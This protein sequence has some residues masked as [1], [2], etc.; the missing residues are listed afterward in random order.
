MSALKPIFTSK[1]AERIKIRLFRAAIDSILCYG[2]ET[3]P[4]MPTLSRS[5]DSRYRR[6]LRSALGIFYPDRI[7]NDELFAKTQL[8]LLSTTLRRRRL[9]LVGHILR[10]QTRSKSPLGELLLN[11][12]SGHLRPSSQNL[13]SDRAVS[14]AGRSL[15]YTLLAG[16]LL[17]ADVTMAM[18][19]SLWNNVGGNTVTSS[20]ATSNTSRVVGQCV[21]ECHQMESC[22][23]VAFDPESDICYLQPTY[24]P[25]R[26]GDDGPLDVYTREK[27]APDVTNAHVTK[28]RVTPSSLDGDVSC[29]ADY[30]LSAEERPQVRCWL[31]SGAWTTLMN[32]TCK[33]FAWRNYTVHPVV[34]S[35]PR[36]STLGLCVRVK[37]TPTPTP[38]N[39]TRV[40]VNLGASGN[41]IVLHVSI[42]WNTGGYEKATILNYKRGTDWNMSKHVE[43]KDPSPPFLF[44]AGVP[45]VM[46]ITAVSLYTFTV[47]VNGAYYGNFTGVLPVTD[48]IN[49]YAENDVSIEYLIIGC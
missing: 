8:P 3:I 31:N 45:F 33:Q 49:V 2:M 12:E 6:M 20:V 24:R 29:D 10:M 19:S 46:V 36:P 14:M 1:A 11:S 23:S 13:Q 17:I 44:A 7:S 15:L 43:L 39:N 37:G 21:M 22:V 38:T 40:T 18:T 5:I 27:E 26:Q 32:A 47:Q 4:L 42:R 30:M 35:L 34:C 16:C 28:W 48:V 25:A 9:R 41:D